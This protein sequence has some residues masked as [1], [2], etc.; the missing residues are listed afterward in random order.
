MGAP[1]YANPPTEEEKAHLERMTNSRTGTDLHQYKWAKIILLSAE[2][3]T[4]PE[5]ASR[6]DL[7]EKRVRYRIH[8]WN[9]QRLAGLK[10][11]K[12]PGRRRKLTEELGERLSQLLLEHTP[13]EVGLPGPNWRLVDLAQAAVDL[14]WVEAI[15]LEGVRLALKRAGY[16]YQRLKRWITPTDPEYEEKKNGYSSV[17]L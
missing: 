4:V 9:E 6:V 15:S 11:R 8:R 14:G 7:S 2:G 13:E 5:I 1:I 16:S 10:R 17:S 12:P 3:K